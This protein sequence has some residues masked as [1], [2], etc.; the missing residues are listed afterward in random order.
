[1]RLEH[2]LA[3][4]DRE[5]RVSPRRRLELLEE[6]GSDAEGLQDELERRGRG[7]RQAQRAALR[8]LVPTGEALKLLE[9]QHAPRLG[10]WIRAV[11]WLERVERLGIVTVAILAGTA[12][13]L[14][15]RWPGSLDV[16]SILAWPQVVVVA[17]LAANW[18]QAAGRLWIDGDLR[19]ARRRT[20]WGR[21]VG[22]MVAAAALGS[23]GAAWEG[24]IALGVLE[25]ETV[26]TQA[27]WGALRRAVSFAGLGLAAATFGLFGWLSLTPRMI[28]D[29]TIE[30][31]ISAFF[32]RS[33]SPLTAISQTSQTQRT[34]QTQQGRQ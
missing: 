27:I 6:L 19:P 22:L 14:V 11:G 10:R 5:L 34:S 8:R 7:P 32:S 26:S 25:G 16:T 20:L 13:A 29:E 28:T 3:R 1:M 23:L 30:R 4:V 24:Y 12:A 2:P 15:I 9:A 17:L 31:R 18:A 33:R 21:Q